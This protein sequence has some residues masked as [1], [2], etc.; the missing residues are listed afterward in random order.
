MSSKLDFNNRDDFRPENI[1]ASFTGPEVFKLVIASLDKSINDAEFEVSRL[2]RIVKR[3]ADS[4]QVD[5]PNV[6]V[7]IPGCY[8][9]SATED[10]VALQAAC[11]Q[12][13]AA[14]QI[15]M[16]VTHAVAGPSVY[17]TTAEAVEESR[18]LFQAK[19]R[20]ILNQK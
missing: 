8:R 13:C 10:Q 12:L 3:N 6:G 5:S 2:M 9:S 18:M 1:G 11:A 4:L 16:S 15:Q 19:A 14:K 7:G 20:E 17:A